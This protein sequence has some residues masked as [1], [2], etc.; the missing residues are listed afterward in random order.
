MTLFRDLIQQTIT[1]LSMVSGS[2]V[3]T[4]AEDSIA[5]KL[6]DAF[7]LVIVEE[8]WPDY[9]QWG[10]CT[11]DGVTGRSTTDLPI[12]R[13]SDIRAVYRGNTDEQLKALPSMINPYRIVSTRPLFITAD[14]VV[15]NRPFVVWPLNVVET[16]SIHMRVV[17]DTFD[18]D[19][20]VKMDG[21]LLRYGAAWMYSED[22]A[23]AP[24]AI[25][26]FQGLFNERLKQMRVNLS[27]IPLAL[28]YAQNPTN[29]EWFEP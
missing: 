2:D 12:T 3:Q 26:K 29:T 19:D 25:G 23:T 5:Q 16:L 1:D 20:D 24:G 22:D 4:Y 11:L 13:Y 7:Q 6:M 17:P 18:L 14:T 15:A 28:D 8:W 21:L 9:M 27:N 10:Q